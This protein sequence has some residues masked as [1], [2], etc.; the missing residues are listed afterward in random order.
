MKYK[1]YLKWDD[2]AGIWYSHS[3]DIPGLILQSNSVEALIERLRLAAPEIL[4]L[5]GQSTNNVTLDFKAERVLSYSQH[6]MPVYA[7]AYA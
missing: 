3:N 6:K 1:I 7:E 5:S 2:E 4:E